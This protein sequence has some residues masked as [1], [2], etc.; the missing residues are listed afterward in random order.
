MSPLLLPGSCSPG[1]LQKEVLESEGQ[2][3][4]EAGLP[5]EQQDA[6]WS[7]GTGDTVSGGAETER[8]GGPQAAPGGKGI[9]RESGG[10][11]GGRA[12]STCRGHPSPGASRTGRGLRTEGFP[13]ATSPTAIHLVAGYRSGS[14]QASS[15]LSRSLEGRRGREGSAVRGQPR[16]DITWGA[17]AAGTGPERYPQQGGC[18]GPAR[19]N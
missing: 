16:R 7:G 4:G 11:S 5:A 2:R 9:S 3:G 10:S 15:G 19:G 8:A 17:V 13:A 6:G 18:A 14:G 12:A 1:L